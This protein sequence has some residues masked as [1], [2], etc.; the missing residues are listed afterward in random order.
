MRSGGRKKTAEA[1]AF[2]PPRRLAYAGEP[3]SHEIVKRS[4]RRQVQEGRVAASYREA[5]LIG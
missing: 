4:D 1:P 3:R 5:R 2:A